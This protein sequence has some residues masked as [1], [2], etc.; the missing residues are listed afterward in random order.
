MIKQLIIAAAILTSTTA[1]ATE[2]AL[3][4]APDI[5]C[6]DTSRTMCQSWETRKGV[7]G[8]MTWTGRKSPGSATAIFHRKEGGWT[9]ELLLAQTKV[10]RKGLYG[11][12]RAC[13][14]NVCVKV[15]RVS[16]DET[17]YVHRSASVHST[18]TT[19]KGLFGGYHTSGTVRYTPASTTAY[20]GTGALLVTDKP[21]KIKAFV[22]QLLSTKRYELFEK[23]SYSGGPKSIGQYRISPGWWWAIGHAWKM[24]Y[25]V[26]SRK[27][28]NELKKSL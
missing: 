28:L 16:G 4:S 5:K 11:I 7:K 17:T 23:E 24:P 27:Y 18:V 15:D 14:G 21:E 19:T 26:Q 9:A 13:S 25:H 20:H 2:V 3:S 8:K 12:T 1:S 6:V 10:T 22:D